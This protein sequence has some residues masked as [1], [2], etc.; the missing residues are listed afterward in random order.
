MKKL[1]TNDAILMCKS[2][3]NVFMITE[4][5]TLILTLLDGNLEC[6]DPSNDIW[7]PYSESDL[8]SENGYML[9]GYRKFKNDNKN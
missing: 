5:L 7:M 6:Y 9:V 4:D 8:V 1:K 2:N 3:K